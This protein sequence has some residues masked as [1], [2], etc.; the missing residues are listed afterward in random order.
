[1][2]KACGL[3]DNQGGTARAL[4]ELQS[5]D[6]Q[7]GWVIIFTHDVRKSPSPWGVTPEQYADVLD[8]V[9]ASGARVITV[10][11]MVERLNVAAESQSAA[12]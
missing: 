2:L 12:A 1:M 6:D 5:L 7:D 10:G 11:D 4:Q 8:A 3:Q 9:E